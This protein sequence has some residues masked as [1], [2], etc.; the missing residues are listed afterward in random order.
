M[1]RKDPL[2]LGMTFN[3]KT[4]AANS[5]IGETAVKKKVFPPSTGMTVLL[6]WIFKCHGS[7][8]P[9]SVI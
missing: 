7:Y 4:G 9:M 1:K 5:N 2:S 3:R 8:L 6:E